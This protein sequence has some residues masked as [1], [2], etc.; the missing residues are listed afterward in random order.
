MGNTWSAQAMVSSAKE[1]YAILE[2]MEELNKT[3]IGN[4]GAYGRVMQDNIKEESEAL[5]NRLNIL[6]EE[7][8]SKIREKTE[9]V[10]KA[11]EQLAALE[12]GTSGKIKN[13]K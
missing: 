7:V 6:V 9:Y 12:S 11:G 4:V 5:V 1:I 2:D 10:E 3:L 8:R 13:L